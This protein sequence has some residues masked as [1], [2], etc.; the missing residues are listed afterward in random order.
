[1]CL[2]E[3]GGTVGDIE[4]MVFLE[5]LR[6]LQHKVGKDNFCHVHV[7]LIPV[8]GA[9]GEQK[10]KPLQ[11]SI[12]EL[13]AA[14]LST[15]IIVC[16]SSKPVE[17]HVLEKIS[18]FCMIP[19]TH[20]ISV[21]DVP[22]LYHVPL[23]LHHQGVSS[24]L[25]SSLCMKHTLC[26]RLQFACLAEKYDS[27]QDNPVVRIGIVGKYS[28]LKDSYLSLLKAIHHASLALKLRDEIVWIDTRQVEETRSITESIDCMIIPGGFGPRGVEGKIIAAQHARTHNVPFLG[29]CLG[30]QVAVIEYARHVLGWKHANSIEF[31]EYTDTPV[32]VFMPEI[33]V[34]T[35]GGT[36]R[37]GTRATDID[38]Y[39]IAYDI[40]NE[41]EI[42]ERHRHRY[43][44][45]IDYVQELQQAG[46]LFSGTGDH[47]KRM[48]IME[49]PTHKFYIAVQF[50]PE[51][52]S[53]PLYPSPLF[54]ELLRQASKNELLNNSHL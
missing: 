11:N 38:Q 23:L 54:V 40:Y 35:M 47:G 37:L 36:M 8:I 41:H 10:S 5:A 33:P 31:D 15:D 43:E 50:H 21:H 48:E 52:T 30:M 4:S 26:T 18:L 1:V 16:R 25:L 44:I 53:R 45:N 17:K 46:L 13:R 19:D 27:C 34:G 29:I 6:Q 3:L 9:V 39:S 24:I 28:G 51:F 12:K 42:F 49:L 14:G 22:S 32:V 2:V 20:I 7:S